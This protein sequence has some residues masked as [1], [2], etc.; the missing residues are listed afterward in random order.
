M[1][2]SSITSGLPAFPTPRILPSLIPMSALIIPSF[3]SMIIALVI[4]KSA[5]S[6]RNTPVAC[7]SPSLA[8]FPPPNTNSSP[9]FMRSFSISITKSVSASLTLSP[10]VGPNNSTYLFRGISNA[11][12]SFSIFSKTFLKPFS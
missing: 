11:V 8:L 10:V 9:Y 6:S 3:G 12:D 7:P 4:T 1:S 2:M 5:E